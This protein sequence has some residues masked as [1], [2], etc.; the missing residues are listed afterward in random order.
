MPKKMNEIEG[1]CAVKRA[2]YKTLK[3]F[4]VVG[5]VLGNKLMRHTI[6]HTNQFFGLGKNGW[7]LAPGQGGSPKTHN[8][9]VFPLTKKMRDRY[10]IGLDKRSLVKLCHL[11]FKKT[12]KLVG[13]RKKVLFQFRKLG[14]YSAS[15]VDFTCRSTQAKLSIKGIY[16]ILLPTISIGFTTMAGHG[17]LQWKDPSW[18]QRHAFAPYLVVVLMMNKRRPPG[19]G[20]NGYLYVSVLGSLMVFA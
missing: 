16:S 11:F 1:I 3:C 2:V 20:L 19:F 15:G 7:P 4:Q 10:G 6:H 9:N 18:H 5:L 17:H 8:F 14:V 12:P 13:I